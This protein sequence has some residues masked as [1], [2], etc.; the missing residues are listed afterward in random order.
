MGWGV[1]LPGKGCMMM[2]VI[3]TIIIIH[4]IIIGSI[5]IPNIII[6]INSDSDSDSV[7]PVKSD[8]VWMLPNQ[9][10]Q[11]NQKP[12][13]KFILSN[14]KKTIEAAVKANTV[15]FLFRH[16]SK[17]TKIELKRRR[18]QIS[19]W[20]DGMDRTTGNFQ[21]PTSPQDFK[22]CSVYEQFLC[23]TETFKN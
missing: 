6:I 23:Y 17:S 1:C 2:I 15:Q 10:N 8:L 3:I 11:W 5:G 18:W 12:T 22:P 19:S 13:L 4:I 20:A 21:I 16:G 7:G 9:K 14:Q